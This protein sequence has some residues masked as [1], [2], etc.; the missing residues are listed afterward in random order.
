MM[1]EKKVGWKPGGAST[2]RK[3][4]YPP[5][6]SLSYVYLKL[7][8]QEESEEAKGL[9]SWA[10]GAIAEK[11]KSF[12]AEEKL[13][14]AYTSLNN[15]VQKEREAENA[16]LSKHLHLT[17]AE[18]QGYDFRQLIENFNK[19]LNLE[20][21]Y[22]TNVERV[23]NIQNRQGYIDRLYTVVNYE[24]PEVIANWMNGL[25]SSIDSIE[26]L[27]SGQYDEEIKQQ[28]ASVL[29]TKIREIYKE[30]SAASKDYQQFA[31]MMQN[32]TESDPLIER[33]M[34]N[35]GLN[36]DQ[37][38]ESIRTKEKQGKT[39][40]NKNI[41]LQRRGGN[42]F[43]DFYQA[44]ASSIVA[45]KGGVAFHTGALNNMKADHIITFGIE[46]QDKLFE[47]IYKD[48]EIDS[49]STRLKNIQAFESLFQELKGIEGEIVFV[50]DKNYNLT[51]D[52]FAVMKGFAAESPTLNNLAGVLAKANVEGIEDL[53][54][55]LANTGNERYNSQTESIE[56]YLATKIANFLFDDVVITDQLDN[57]MS[58]VSR[59]HVFN[60]GGILVPLSVFLQ[61]AYNALVSIQG[62]YTEYVSVKYHA[63]KISYSEQIDG[64]TLSDWDGL[65]SYV[66]SKSKVTIH[67]FGNFMNFVQSNL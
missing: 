26:R 55:T 66:I 58:S 18:V 35:Y 9:A 59:I 54:F 46:N 67:F 61:G 30:G 65:Y 49:N 34:Q 41:F 48:L 22:R 5:Q 20:S 56:R 32:I 47:D 44:V 10:K 62:D 16:F 14:R 13:Q 4:Q 7:L 42:V 40:T 64:L 28:I 51:A 23:K 43:E 2:D 39:I 11:A 38:R 36:P 37:L 50:S 15:L 45:V 3:P 29:T 52:S 31:V 21:T 8:D 1:A 17:L 24:L 53:I 57:N 27:M 60:L 25:L 63:A 19:I 12:A 6:G 33:I